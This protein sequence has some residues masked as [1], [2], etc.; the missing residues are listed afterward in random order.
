MTS[1]GGGLRLCLRVVTTRRVSDSTLQAAKA[2]LGGD[3]GVV[4][5]RARW[6]CIR[7]PPIVALDETP[8]GGD[9]N[10]YPHPD[11]ARFQVEQTGVPICG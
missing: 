11:P 1:P 7:S 4:I 6:A 5:G 8:L 10:P 2:V 3:R 9:T